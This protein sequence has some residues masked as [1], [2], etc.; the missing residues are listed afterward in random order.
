[1]QRKFFVVGVLLVLFT[2]VLSACAS[3]TP[4]VPA[5]PEAVEATAAPAAVEATLHPKWLKQLLHP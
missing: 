2:M 5:A 1:M 4:E 3:A